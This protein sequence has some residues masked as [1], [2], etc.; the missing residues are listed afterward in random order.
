[1]CAPESTSLIQMHPTYD[2]N[3]EL[4]AD[5][6]ITKY[7]VAV[8]DDNATPTTTFFQPLNTSNQ[9]PHVC[10]PLLSLGTSSN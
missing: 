2:T 10:P 3:S 7:P 6:T 1:M 4:E 5:N 8:N 9:G